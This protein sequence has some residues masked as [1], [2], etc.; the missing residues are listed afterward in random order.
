MDPPGRFVYSWGWDSDNPL[1]DSV[2][3][4]EFLE[5]GDSTEVVL[6]HAIADDKERASHEGS[7]TSILEKFD[8]TYSSEHLITISR[9]AVSRRPTRIGAT[10]TSLPAYWRFDAFRAEAGC[11]SIRARN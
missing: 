3:T 10:Q 5:R 1:K 7:W 8:A 4:I 9:A 2:V 11:A 6:T